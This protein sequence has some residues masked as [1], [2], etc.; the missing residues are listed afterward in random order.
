MIL[1]ERVMNVSPS[2]TLAITAKAKKMIGEGKDVISF[3]AGEPDF[4][5]PR[6]IKD[7]AI[8]AINE[9]KTRYTPA[10]GIL[11]LKEAV[12]NK[13]EKD[14]GIKYDSDQIIICT[15]AKQALANALFA[16][17]NEG[18]EVLVISPYWVSYPELIRIAGGVPVFVDTKW[19]EG[20]KL[21]VGQLDSYVTDKTKA[22]ILNTPNNPTGVA[23]SR[24]EIEEIAEFCKKNDIIVISDEIYE[25]LLYGDSEHVSIA[26]ISQDAYERTIVINGVSKSYA[27]TGWRIGYAAASKKITKLMGSLQSHITSNPCSIAQYAS[28]EAISGDQS[29]VET[30]R[31]EFEAR[32]NYMV[33]RIN[34][35]DGVSCIIPDGAF[36]VMMNISQIIKKCYNGSIIKDSM[37]FSNILLDAEGVAVIPGIAFGADEFVRLSYATSMDNIIEGLDRIARFIETI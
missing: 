29:E 18:D 28:L 16:I 6:H 34:N 10:S 13:L 30:M 1:S 21:N 12:A 33:N 9:G 19:E 36:Y 3:G 22:I 37:D 26:S 14:N 23:Y 4:D 35:I 8:R 25:K 15:G 11:E 5:T 2:M 17:I 7:A 31:A 32:R 24:R 27:M 20:F